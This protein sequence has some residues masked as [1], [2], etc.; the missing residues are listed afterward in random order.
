MRNIVVLLLISLPFALLS[1]AAGKQTTQNTTSVQSEYQK[2]E[3]RQ[4]AEQVTIRRTDYGVP[5]IDAENIQSAGF[6]LGYVQMEDYGREVVEGLIRARGEWTRY[7]EEKVSDLEYAIDSDAA[8]RR[9]YVRAVETW[10]DL[11]QDTRKITKGFV[12]GINRYIELHP[13]EFEDWV[14]PFFTVYDVHARGINGPSSSSIRDFLDALGRRQEQEENAETVSDNATGLDG[15]TLWARLAERAEE[16]HPDVGSN[17][18]A[19]APDRTKSG[20]AILVRNPHLSWDAGYYEAQVTVPGKLNFYGDFRIGRPLGIVGGFNERLGWATTNNYP[21]LDEI[22]AFEADPERPDHFL[23][24]GASLPIQKESVTIEFKNGKSIGLE[25]R[26]FLSTPFG[27]VIHR[28]NGKV[29]VI[30]SAGDGEFRMGEQ[31][32]NMMKSQNLSEW[33]EAMRMR[34]RT[35]SNLTYADADGNIF[36]VWNAAA[37]DLPHKSGNDTLAVEVSSRDQIWSDLIAWDDLPQLHNPEG[38]YLHNENDPFHFTNLNEV[39]DEEDFPDHFPDPQYR[40]RS[41]HSDQL[42]N[43]EK[44][45]SLEDIV[46]L[47][48]SMD[49]LL[50]HRVKVD[51]IKA[52]R[53]HNP[54]DEIVE[55]IEQIENWDNTVRKE[56]KGGILFKTWWWRYQ[57]TADSTSVNSS[58][59]SAGFSATPERLFDEVWSPDHPAETPYGLADPKR[60]AEAFEWAVEKAK[61]RYGDWDYAWGD[62]HRAHLGDKDLAVGGCT[63]LLGCFR[64]LWFIDHK[65]DD[66]K[67]EVRGGDGW[68]LAVEFGDKPKAY[69][70]LAYGQSVKEDSPYFNDQLKLFTNNKMKQVVFTEEDIMKQFVREY[71]PG[72]EEK[73]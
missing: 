5:H 50:A 43:N 17:A 73:R 28:G 26:E 7:N 60:A 49:M 72:E 56:S 16:P 40:L 48:H 18:W 15:S 4:L 54:E 53:E 66:Q 62:V 30:K 11:E 23:L 21:D 34:A 39:F 55:A 31:F 52:V 45:F 36:Y 9:D 27:P 13:E 24:D 71:H 2:P 69:S 3:V 10:D 63:G 59:E 1:C 12:A 14:Q 29:Y 25:T 32:L 65:Y 19:L 51:L 35:A 42:I 61:E 70:V 64:V 38:G 37:P 6:A 41:Q 46:E 58:P 67:L 33:K 57:E 47:K 22:Y 44:K 8:N 68:V 20:K